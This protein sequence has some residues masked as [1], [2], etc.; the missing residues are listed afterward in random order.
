M[1]RIGCAAVAA[2]WVA[3]CWSNVL[4][5]ET[6]N[7]PSGAGTQSGIDPAS[8]PNP[9]PALKTLADMTIESDRARSDALKT[10]IDRALSPA[11]SVAG[12][13]TFA[14]G[15]VARDKPVLTMPVR[16]RTAATI[17]ETFHVQNVILEKGTLMHR[18]S[19]RLGGSTTPFE[20]WCGMGRIDALLRKG[21]MYFCLTKTNDGLTVAYQGAA[22]TGSGDPFLA[23]GLMSFLMVAPSDKAP[24][25]AMTPVAQAPADMTAEL[26][27]F[28]GPRA[29]RFHW[30]VRKAD[31]W[32][33]RDAGEAALTPDLS[34]FAVTVGSH[35]M[36]R[37]GFAFIALTYADKPATVTYD[38]YVDALAQRPDLA[39]KIDA[40]ERTPKPANDAW[41]MGA[42]EMEPSTLTLDDS[43]AASGAVTLNMN[44]HIRQKV[45]LSA[46]RKDGLMLS[47]HKD[48]IFYSM[49]FNGTY[50]NGQPY[51][52]PGWC[53]PIHSQVLGIQSQFQA[54]FATDDMR[55]TSAWNYS[56]Y[57]ETVPYES[58]TRQQVSAFLPLLPPHVVVPIDDS[59]K[60]Q[61]VIRLR[62]K[63]RD[64]VQATLFVVDGG[65]ERQQRDAR[66]TFDAAGVAIYD[67]GA[68]RLTLTRDGE[69]GLKSVLGDIPSPH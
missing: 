59:D 55:S 35:Q 63:G 30:R 21:P 52:V 44:A 42:L 38:G 39:A 67:I 11:L 14:S 1:K 49:R 48:D 62:R 37:V 61:L 36:F 68:K 29:S 15:A 58:L 40:A 23:P 60:R 3:T 27:A 69:D 54:C 31:A 32:E 66:L 16:F 65:G 28:P 13:I 6:P 45:K 22:S 33:W 46:D 9:A 4:A 25:P 19:F 8:R 20:A 43:A 2:I 17:D 53:G 47:F 5:Q 41:E 12:D 50:G 57:W 51:T 34:S 26:V 7:V 24:F 18:E 56:A 10:N 64:H